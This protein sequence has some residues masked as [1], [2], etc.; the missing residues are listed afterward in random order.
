MKLFLTDIGGEGMRTDLP[1]HILDV[2]VASGIAEECHECPVDDVHVSAYGPHRMWHIHEDH[3]W[4]CV[5]S[6]LAD[7]GIP[8][9]CACGS[10]MRGLREFFGHDLEGHITKCDKCKGEL[11]V[12]SGGA[13]CVHCGWRS[14]VD[15]EG[16]IEEFDP[17]TGIH[18]TVRDVTAERGAFLEGYSFIVG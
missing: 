11:H 2:L 7:L 13:T 15:A 9:V 8:H 3:D 17:K 6:A 12:D 16:N 5:D 4:E 10:E 18:K 1:L 14:W